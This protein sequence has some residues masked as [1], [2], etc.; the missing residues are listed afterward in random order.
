MRFCGLLPT[1]VKCFTSGKPLDDS[2]FAC[3]E[4]MRKVARVPGVY[5]DM[6]DGMW[7]IYEGVP[8]CIASTLASKLDSELWIEL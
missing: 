1:K 7:L 5:Y 3:E 8:E 4:S 6:A 2:L